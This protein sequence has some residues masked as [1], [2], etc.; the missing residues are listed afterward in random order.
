MLLLTGLIVFWVIQ[1][2][3]INFPLWFIITGISCL[4]AVFID[5]LRP[6]PGFVYD[7][8]AGLYFS[9]VLLLAVIACIE[10]FRYFYEHRGFG[11]GKNLM[12]RLPDSQSHKGQKQCLLTFDDG[13]SA[14]WTPGILSFLKDNGIY[15]VF[16]LV[17]KHVEQ[18]PEIAGHIEES[19]CEAA[20]HSHNHKPLP[21]LFSGDLKAEIE[22][23]F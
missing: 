2:I 12:R 4:T 3:K 13:P 10:I 15:A 6:L 21:F 22:M 8:Q 20:V 9:I 16:F 5:Y 18:N 14:D 23:N 17:G 1:Y 19:G 11:K 7:S